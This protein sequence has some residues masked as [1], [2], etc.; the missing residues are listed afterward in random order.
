MK[1]TDEG[2]VSSERPQF[3]KAFDSIL[4]SCVGVSNVTSRR[5][6]QNV[7]ADGPMILTDLGIVMDLIWDFLKADSSIMVRLEPGSKVR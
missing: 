3:S 1:S 6:K 7:N 5:N 4:V 2:I